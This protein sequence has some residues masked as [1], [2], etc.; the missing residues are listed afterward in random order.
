V[1]RNG[2]PG[3]PEP[4]APP[5]GPAQNLRPP[6]CDRVI[7]VGFYPPP[8][9]GEAIHVR[10]LAQ[11]LRERGMAVDILNLNRR[12]GPSAE[13]RS[14]RSQI[15]RLKMLWSQPNHS[16]VLHLHA[17]GH[18]WMSWVVIAVVALTVRLKGITAAITVHSGLFPAYVNTFGPMRRRLGGW[19][20]WSFRRVVCVNPDIARAVH[21]LGISGPRSLVVSPFLGVP[22]GLMLSVADRALID[23]F[24]PL[25]VAVGGGDS[26]PERGLPIVAYACKELL[27]RNPMLGVLFLGARV[28]RT[29]ELL[30]EQLGLSERAVCLGEVSHDRCLSLLRAAD[31]VVRSTFADGDSITVREAIALG[32]PVVAS[33][34][35]YR[36]E[37]VVLFEK[38]DAADLERKLDRMI[39]ERARPGA[40][41]AARQDGG[42]TL[43]RLY[44]GLAGPNSDAAWSDPPGEPLADTGT[45]RV[46]LE[47]GG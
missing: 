8:F 24:D 21:R 39:Q 12:A 14:A 2:L 31:V 32:V 20:L 11:F 3:G 28:G 38:G 10:Q 9:G 46:I 36:P 19:L 34:T 26:D 15:G 44:L 25:L 6:V 33:A 4:T 42:Q 5:I 27:R 18:N 29:I 47:P 16:A 40:N 37:G 41:D 35:D 23:R 7:V 22:A 30:I 43:W 13:Y 17:I 1:S 45:S